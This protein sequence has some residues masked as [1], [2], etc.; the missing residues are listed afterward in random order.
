MAGGP[1]APPPTTAPVAAL[2]C[3][4]SVALRTVACEPAGEEGS[5]AA[6][7]RHVLGGQGEYVRLTSFGANY[8]G[9]VFSTYVNV[10]NLSNLPLATQDGATPD[11][12]GLRVFFHSGPT[13]TSGAGEVS[14]SDP[15]GTASFTA[16]DQP[17]IQYG[18]TISAGPRNADLGGDGILSPGETSTGLSWVFFV[19]PTV[20]TFSFVVYVSTHTPPGAISTI[21]P[22]VTGASSGPLVP[23]ASAT[24]TGINFDATPQNNTVT[25]GGLPAPVTGATATSLTVTVPCVASGTAA[26]QVTRGGMKGKPAPLP[27]QAANAR[28]LGVGESAVMHDAAGAACSELAATGAASRYVVTVY[29]TSTNPLG[30][31]GFRIAGGGGGE[32]PGA[33]AEAPVSARSLAAPLPRHGGPAPSLDVQIALARAR[34]AD[35]AHHALLER[36]LAAAERLRRRFAGDPRMRASRSAAALA[37]PPLTR[38]FR[39]ANFNIADFCT[40][41]FP[42]TATRVYYD[43]KVAIYE[44]DSVAAPLKGANNPAMQDYYKRIGDTYNESMEPILTGSFGDP[45]R[46]D[47]LTDHNGV[48]VM[49]FTPIV[50][51]RFPSYDGFVVGCDMFP[52]DEGAGNTNTSSNF[53]EIF[54]ARVPTEAGTGYSEDTPDYWFWTMQSTIIHEAKHVASFNARVANGAPFYEAAWLEEGTARHIEELWAR[55]AVYNVAWKGNTGYGSAA[56]PGSLY[57]D[58]RPGSSAACAAQSPYRPTYSMYRH[59]ASLYTF[60]RQPTANSPF[61]RTATGGVFTHYAAS[62]SL[63]RYAIDRYGSSDA[64]FLSALGQASTYGTENLAARAGVPSERLLGEWALSLYTDDLAGPGGAS[65]GPQI[66]TWNFPEIFAGMN[67]D[68]PTTLY[69]LRYPLTPTQLS[70]GFGDVS[71]PSIAGGGVAYFEVSGT[72]TAP[73]LLR[74]LSTGG[75]APPSWLRIAVARIQ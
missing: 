43:G 29:N 24:L 42:V 5:G 45:L 13:A 7:A 17:Y 3:E 19:A 11:P 52:N 70:F 26:V 22:Q 62:W 44:D 31:T 48:L 73:Q 6:F 10:Q 75:G 23:G 38:A 33:P 2:A 63:V 8:S 58:V 53:G 21:A 65:V 37:E 51:V 72:Q 9:G 74:L 30:T 55:Q 46:R 14:V 57:C 61:G 60:L 68:F 28:V 25:I 4:A 49:L 32:A 59:F 67:A 54:F 40:S 66:A 1:P 47:A 18:G 36:N 71:V 41:Y 64:A 34:T 69:P 20:S 35:E 56:S 39:V 16:A 12:E 15:A 27:A 50:N